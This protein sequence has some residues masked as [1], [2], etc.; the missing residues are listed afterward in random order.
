MNSMTGFGRANIERDGRKI[1]LELKSV[2]HRYLDLNIRMPRSLSSMEEHIRNKMKNTL[3]RGHVDIF[4]YYKN[5]R[6]DAKQ[7]SVDKGLATA[8]AKALKEVKTI[9]GA[10]NDITA[11]NIARMNDVL[12][13][14][15]TEED[16]GVLKELI[17]EALDSA[18]EGLLDMRLREGKSLKEDMLQNISELE[19]RLNEVI[20][21]APLVPKEYK[22]KLITRLEDLM[23]DTDV[24]IDDQKIMTEI[25][26]YC[27]KC[28]LDEETSRLASHINEF[29]KKCETEGAIGRSMDFLV[30]EMNREANT[31]CSKANDIEIT[32]IGLAMK[33]IVEKIREQ[34]QN[35]E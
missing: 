27:D 9:T 13:I 10:K 33:N 30:Q 19:I 6:Q 4:I 16:E 22:E 7:I 15:E 34:V 1:S 31:I 20:K 29:R 2:N 23:K 3:D 12:Q 25:A 24:K 14:S 11:A 35:V 32:N 28:S 8:Y 18:L 5:T 21:R 17:T 26:V